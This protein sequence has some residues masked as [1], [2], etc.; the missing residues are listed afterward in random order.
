M[1]QQRCTTEHIKAVCDGLTMS[2]AK[3]VDTSTETWLL[4]RMWKQGCL[5]SRVDAVIGTSIWNYAL[6]LSAIFDRRRTGVCVLESGI[7]GIR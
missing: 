1:R 7:S 5:G 3:G 6:G 4:V 2:I